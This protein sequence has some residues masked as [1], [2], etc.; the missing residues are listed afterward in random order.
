MAATTNSSHTIVS[1]RTF[2]RRVGLACA[3]VGVGGILAACD[4]Q[5]PT[6][7]ASAGKT[8]EQARPAAVNSGPTGT[9]AAV[10]NT[11]KTGATTKRRSQR[12]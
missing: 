12:T 5:E 1:R 11:A 9:S 10:A 3:W 8:V 7:G 4:N 2:L 6:I